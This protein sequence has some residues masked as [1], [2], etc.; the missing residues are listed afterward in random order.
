MKD[1][2]VVVDMQKDFVYGKLGS[3]ATKKIIPNIKKLIEKFDGKIY[4]TLD[5][6]F[7]NYYETQEGRKLPVIHCIKNSEGWEIIDELKKSLEEKN[8]VM[9]EKNTFGSS[10]LIDKLKEEKVKSVTLAGLLT[11][12]CVIS[13]AITIKTFFPELEIY[14]K[15]DSCAG[16]SADAHNKSLQVME[17]LQINII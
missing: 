17:G 2:L 5:T 4:Y 14:V 11:D 6:H 16:S 10:K 13:N 15:S 3:E 12:I 9:I 1:I 7:E 8:A